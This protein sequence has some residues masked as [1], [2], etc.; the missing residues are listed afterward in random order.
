MITVAD[1]REKQAR[2]SSGTGKTKCKEC[3]NSQGVVRSLSRTPSPQ[4]KR[5]WG[6]PQP[7]LLAIAEKK[8]M[9]PLER[10]AEEQG[11]YRLVRLNPFP[12]ANLKQRTELFVSLENN[13]QTNNNQD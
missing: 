13:K 8:K 3:W 7:I 6:C 5:T 9:F 11:D 2:S 1:R 10:K 12:I 4:E